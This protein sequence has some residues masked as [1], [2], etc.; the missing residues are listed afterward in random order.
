[1][2]RPI[3]SKEVK[4]FG[5]VL[6]TRGKKLLFYHNDPD[7]IASATLILR[8]FPDFQA[9]PRKG[10]IMDRAFVRDIVERSPDTVVFLDMPVD[11]EYR[12]IKGIRKG[13]PGV[14]IAV[15]DHHIFERDLNQIGILHINPRFR[16]KGIY[17]PSAWLVYRML[18]KLGLDVKGLVWIASIGIIGD[19]GITDARDVLEECRLEYPYLLRGNPMKS[20][21][22]D[23]AKTL[24]AAITL[25]G[26]KGADEALRSLRKCDYFEDLMGIKKLKHWRKVVDEEIR[27]LVRGFDKAKETRGVVIFYKIESRLNLGSVISTIISEKH[28]EDIIVIR[29]KSGEGWKVSV[30]NQSGQYNVG[31]IVKRAV[32]GLGSGGGHEKAA[33]GVVPKW[34]EFRKRFLEEVGKANKV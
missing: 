1:M 34:R 11:Q 12:K 3:T 13:L 18:E 16:K 2:D 6:N 8:F 24:S 15:L 25:K 17:L 31:E 21:L 33:A 22:S 30:R 10:P 4:L 19:Y 28:P 26:M 23:A 29:K 27:E 32:K 5:K 9:I 7:G 14:T 20:R